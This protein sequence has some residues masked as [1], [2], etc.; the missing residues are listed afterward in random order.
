MSTPPFLLYTA[1][2]LITEGRASRADIDDLGRHFD[3]SRLP[4]PYQPANP[5]AGDVGNR[6]A[7]Q[8]PVRFR[9]D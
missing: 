4:D 1:H 7:S 5:A 6:R 3:A 2:G 8:R 9:Y